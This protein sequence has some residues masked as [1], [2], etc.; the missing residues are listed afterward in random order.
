MH[1]EYNFTLPNANDVIHNVNFIYK[2]GN[3]LLFQL[4]KD[5]AYPNK[6]H[7]H[8]ISSLWRTWLRKISML[9]YLQHTIF[10]MEKFLQKHRSDPN[11]A[12]KYSINSAIK[13]AK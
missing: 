5:K 8:D 9:K 10:Y 4:T 6:S 3:A 13:V 1:I 7:H 2:N 11:N 12:K